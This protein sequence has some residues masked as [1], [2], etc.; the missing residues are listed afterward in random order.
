[1]ERGSKM[2]KDIDWGVTITTTF[3]FGIVLL[4]LLTPGIMFLS[5]INQAEIESRL[6]NGRYH[7]NYTPYDFFWS[8]D[9]I[10]I[11]L[12]GGPQSTQNINING[13][14]PVKITQ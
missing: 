10:K 12:E 14:L 6:Y 8:G 9:T 13:A 11:F 1:M 2:F 5:K 3:F 4:F 7:T